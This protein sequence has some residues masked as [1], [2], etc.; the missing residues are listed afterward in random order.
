MK[1]IFL[2]S[3]L[4]FLFPALVANAAT[5]SLTLTN[6]VNVQNMCTFNTT[7]NMGFGAYNP[8]NENANVRATGQLQL[9]CNPGTYTIKI[10]N[11]ANSQETFVKKTEGFPTGGGTYYWQ[12]DCQRRV[13]N[14]SNSTLAYSI[15]MDAGYSTPLGQ[16]QSGGPGTPTNNGGFSCGN[17]NLTLKTVTFTTADNSA[18]FIDLYGLINPNQGDAATMGTYTDSITLQVN[19]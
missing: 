18:Q 19:F 10:N 17:N 9:Y 15:Y 4:A 7:Q 12:Y 2:L 11:G 13:K 14:S 5:K 6:T 16:L 8:L 3:G 1:K